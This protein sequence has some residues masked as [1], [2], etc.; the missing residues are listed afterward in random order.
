[1]RPLHLRLVLLAFGCALALPAGA[2]RDP[3]LKYHPRAGDLPDL[4]LVEGSHQAGAGEGLTQIYDGGYE[5]Y[6]KAGVKRASQQYY[7]LA[8]RTVEIVIH[9][10]K[11]APAA[12]KFFASFCQDTGAKVEPIKLG[13]KTG[14]LCAAPAEGSAYGYLTVGA[15]FVASSVDKAD[16]KPARD[17]LT[18]TGERLAGVKKPAKK[19]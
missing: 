6:T 15:F 19:K 16:A 4:T 10:L 12:V 14:K 11:S 9:E 17:L 1:M 7:K 2:A 5:R 18:V 3:L 13:A 8:G